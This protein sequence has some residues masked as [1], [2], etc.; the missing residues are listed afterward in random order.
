MESIRCNELEKK[1]PNPLPLISD[2]IRE[3]GLEALLSTWKFCRKEW[4]NWNL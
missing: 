2:E 3:N 4:K 1:L